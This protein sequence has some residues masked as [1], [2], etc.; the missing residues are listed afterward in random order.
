MTQFQIRQCTRGECRFR[1][2]VILDAASPA[3]EM[4]CPKC[5]APASVVEAPFA[6]YKQKM[7][8][9][10]TGGPGGPQVEALLD[11]IRSTYNVGSMFRTAD[12]RD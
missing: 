2:P 8:S 3:A 12:G 5:G 7:V 11:N 10:G 4:A 1:F 6:N 9:E